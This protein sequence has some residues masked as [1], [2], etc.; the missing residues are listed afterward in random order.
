MSFKN[1]RYLLT[2]CASPQNRPPP[3]QLKSSGLRRNSANYKVTVQVRANFLSVLFEST[4]QWKMAV[5]S[6]RI[7]Q[8][9]RSW[10]L[11]WAVSVSIWSKKRKTVH[12]AVVLR[13]RSK[14]SAS[15]LQAWLCGSP[16]NQNCWP[17]KF[18]PRITYLNDFHLNKEYL[19]FIK[20]SDSDN[21]IKRWKAVAS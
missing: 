5:L 9:G 6:D 14:R 2:A 1:R 3:R 8:E 7:Q 4:H 16:A 20:L 21:S 17:N 19:K 13:I 18:W 15:S 12:R 11:I 10:R